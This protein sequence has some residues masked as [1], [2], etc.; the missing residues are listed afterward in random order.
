MRKISVFFGVMRFFLFGCLLVFICSVCFADE[1]SQICVV[2]L[3]SLDLS[4]SKIESIEKSLP[5]AISDSHIYLSLLLDGKIV[6]VSPKREVL[7]KQTHFDWPNDS[8]SSVGILWSKGNTLTV[9]VFLSDDP[10]DATISAGGIGGLGGAGLGAAIGGTLAGIF[11]GGLGAPAG[12]AIGAAIGGGIGGAGGAIAGAISAKDT[13]VLE[14]YFED[15]DYFPLSEK[16]EISETNALGESDNA[17]V[18]FA[19]D[20]I[21]KPLPEGSLNLQ[22]KYLVCVKDIFLTENLCLRGGKD[23]QKNRYYLKLKNGE[24]SLR[25]PL[26][27]ETFSLNPGNHFD[28]KFMTV[29][30]NTGESTEITIFEQDKG[31]DDVVFS[32]KV[33]RLNGKNWVFQGKSYSTGP[34][35]QRSF[36]ICE[37]YGPIH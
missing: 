10:T 16:I 13:L 35:D 33:A 34:V 31:R 36:V 20:E 32:S 26:E 6:W 5:A 4:P 2:R 24:S 22:Q 19:M 14:K 12:A 7:P 28:P 11:T 17:S 21:H 18:S 27:K 15:V 23:L 25:W 29:L 37:T 30:V 1:S 3:K 8:I 9:K